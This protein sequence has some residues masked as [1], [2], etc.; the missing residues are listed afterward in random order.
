MENFVD[1][2]CVV[3]DEI[4]NGSANRNCSHC[5][6][7]AL[8]SCAENEENSLAMVPYQRKELMARS[9]P[10]WAFLR[11]VFIFK[12]QNGKKYKKPFLIPWVRRQPSRSTSSAAV[13]PDQKQNDCLDEESGAIVPVGEVAT[14]PSNDI[15]PQ[16]EGLHE[17]F[18]STCRLFTYQELASATSNFCPGLFPI[19]DIYSSLF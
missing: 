10:G 4:Y 1:E 13:Y 5:D 17:R 15:P 12:H 19:F 6:C 9:R 16:L 2:N 7:E 8:S 14:S 11:R 3:I 18:S